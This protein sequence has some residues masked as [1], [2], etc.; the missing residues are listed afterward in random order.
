MLSQ[1]SFI[2]AMLALALC[3]ILTIEAVLSEG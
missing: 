2:I 3:A 1:P